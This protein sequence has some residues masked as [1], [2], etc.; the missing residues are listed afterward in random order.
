MDG[1]QNGR[2]YKA[3]DTVK[4]EI[5]LHH[6]A[7]L[8]EVRAIFTHKHDK[9]AAPL[10]ARGQPR[11]ISERGADGS[12][13]SRLEAETVL[14]PAVTPGVY[15]LARISYETAGGQLGHLEEGEVLS[16]TPQM[17][18]EVVGEPADS[19]EVVDIGFT[20]GY[21]ERPATALDE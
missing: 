6:R 7:N 21:R 12:I 2:L 4:L 14:P 11:Q 17:I 18:F 15:E 3:G 19:P 10:M 9:S 5:V 13:M 1:A 16:D 8:K 20:D